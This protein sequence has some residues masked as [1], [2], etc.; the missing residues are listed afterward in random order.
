MLNLA[1]SDRNLATRRLLMALGVSLLLHF[2]VLSRPGFFSSA[3]KATS[4]SPLQV[5][6]VAPVATVAT[7]GQPPAESASEV[8]LSAQESRVARKIEQQAAKP[9]VPVK[10]AEPKTQEPPS[11]PEVTVK[12]SEA[13]PAA[14]ASVQTSSPPAKESADQSPGVPLP[15]LTGQVKRVAI[16]FEIY[17]GADRQL[18]GSGQHRYVSDI[19]GNYG[20]SIK[21]VLKD[22][23]PAQGQPWQLE[24][25]GT[26]GRQGL[27]PILFQ[28]QGAVS[29]RLM[30]L[31]EVPENSSALPP[32]GRSG[33]MP[34]GLLDRQSLLY[35]FMLQPPA[36]TGGKLWLSDGATHRLYTY[37]LAGIES[38]IIPSLGGVRTIKLVFSTSDSPEIVELWLVPDLHYLPAKVRHIDRQGVITEQVV[39]SLDFS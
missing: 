9:V 25:S 7:P 32:K 15:G 3:K 1:H 11:I 6:L 12:P 28:I 29:E 39:I 26:I 38:F 35:Q 17:S 14:P 4:H 18:T 5:S 8:V 37:R 2:G 31:K 10:P 22:G 27:N 16:D 19:G 34:D 36:L 23:D 21:Q 30:A 13:K 24:I 20:V 33:R